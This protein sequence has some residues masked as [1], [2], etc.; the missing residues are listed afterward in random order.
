MMGN[1]ERVE[2]DVQE[3]EAL[4]TCAKE[5]LPEEAFTKI[6][7]IVRAYLTMMHL[8]EDRQTTIA[9][10]RQMLFGAS[11]E[12]FS[13][14]LKTLDPQTAAAHAQEGN[15]PD[16]EGDK[17]DTPASKGHGRNGAS[18]YSA[19]KKVT[20]LLA[21]LKPG[22][23]CPECIKGKLYENVPPGV[24]V[25]VVGQAPLAA[26][27]YELQKLRCNLCGEVFTAEAPADIG[28]EKYDA[29]AGAMIAT[30]KY[31]GGMP[32]N[33]LAQLQEHMGLPLPAATQWEC[34][35]ALATIVKPAHTEMIQQAAQ[36]A[37]LHNDDTGAKILELMKGKDVLATEQP[38][39]LL[40]GTQGAPQRSG[41]FTSGIV[42]VTG[43]HKIAL[44]YTGCK[45]AGENLLE[46]LKKRSASLAPP[47]QMCDALSRNMPKELQT[48]VAN[49]A[50]HARRKFADVAISFPE[51]CLYVLQVFRQVYAVDAA[52]K[53]QQLCATAR[54]ALH[55]AQSLPLMTALADWIKEQI[56]AKKVEP[57][58][59]LGEAISYMRKHWQKLTLFLHVPDVP[60]DNN[61]CERALKKA[62][63]H[64]KNALFYKTQHGAEVGDLFMSMIHTCQLCGA[65]HFDYLVALQKH[66]HLLAATPADWMPWNYRQT[67]DGLAQQAP[68]A[69]S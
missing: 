56:V 2:I 19:A 34:V 17:Q 62:I 59:G 9:R 15:K 46:L 30:L 21:T 45:H 22:E 4:L 53:E 20:V 64:R 68:L 35:D 12:S 48:I 55:Q 43:E 42:A 65:N 40:Q 47:I 54:L 61:I 26:T 63:L 52:A 33:R 16:G 27:V 36:A 51:G 10:L 14:V 41:V 58:S 18:A 67:V 7:Q 37:V 38:E 8:V 6:E 23:R 50:S 28:T 31:G 3:I 49:C 69:S 60:L 1:I 5:A 29:G 25:R 24:V 57:N 39:D 32:F 13:N 11:T 44:F 66:R